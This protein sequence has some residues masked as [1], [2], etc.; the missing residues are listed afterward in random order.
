M[1]QCFLIH[2]DPNHVSFDSIKN[3]PQHAGLIT[4]I[5]K[6]QWP[7]LTGASQLLQLLPSSSAHFKFYG[8]P[9]EQKSGFFY[10][11]HGHWSIGPSPL[12]GRLPEFLSMQ[13]S[14]LCLY[15]NLCG[16]GKT[17]GVFWTLY[18]AQ[19]AMGKKQH[20]IASSFFFFPRAKTNLKAIGTC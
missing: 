20:I 7:S 1:Q 18:S 6:T 9:R 8:T 4:W 16:L 3:L 2:V 13:N 19:F 12:Q 15:G 10:E 11:Y 5:N 14:C 17:L